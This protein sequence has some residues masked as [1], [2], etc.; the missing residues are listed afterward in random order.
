MMDGKPQNVRRQ[1]PRAR[2]SCSATWPRPASTTCSWRWPGIRRCW[3][4]STAALTSA[5]TSPGEL[6]ARADG[7][8]H[9]PASATT[10]KTTSTRRRGSSPAGTWSWWATAPTTST[11]TTASSTTP[12]S[13]TPTAKK[14]TFDIYPGGGRTIPARAASQGMQDGLD[15]IDALP[16]HPRRPT[17]LATQLYQFFV[18][19]VDAPDAGVGSSASRR[20]STA[21]NG[22]IR[23]VLQRLFLV[24]GF[25]TVQL[26]QA[27]R[28]AGGI[29]RPIDQGGRAGRAS[30]WTRPSP[31]WRLGQTL[32]EPPDVNGWAIGAGVVL[33]RRH[34][35]AHELRRD[36]D[37]EP[38]VQPA[39]DA[40]PYDSRPSRC[41][42]TRSTGF[43]TPFDGAGYNELLGLPA[44]RHELDRLD[45]QLMA[46]GPGRDA[47]VLA[48][49]EYQFV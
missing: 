23:V 34:A 7:A 35:G 5:D 37:R 47:L 30:P 33:D 6:R 10:P 11:P 42:R 31:R 1:R 25:L 3:C 49:P 39:R 41:W 16:R 43:P 19:D 36:A 13:T 9:A 22:S 20:P 44:R 15:L 4:G 24:R 45:T 29:R 8:V 32:F 17:R 26:L 38:A 40:Q 14:F 18:N 2:S 21:P 28:V 27:L 46:K 48:R 12:I